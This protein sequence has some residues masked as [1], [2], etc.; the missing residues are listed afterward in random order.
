[1]YNTQIEEQRDK[2]QLE[3]KNDFADLLHCSEKSVS[4]LH[5]N[6]STDTVILSHT[7]N[8]SST[9]LIEKSKLLCLLTTYHCMIEK[10]I[11]YSV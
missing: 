5:E 1:M 9:I 6:C 8:P 11:Q 7:N 4:W 10:D 2:I 3:L